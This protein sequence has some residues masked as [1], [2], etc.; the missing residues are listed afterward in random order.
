[1]IKN[2]N[3]IT[4]QGFMVNELG[5]KGNELLIYALIYGFSQDGVN[6][7]NGSLQYMADWCNIS[8]IAV[9]NGLKKLVEK[10][11]I[12]KEEKFI[13]NVKFCE[14]SVSIEGSKES[15][16]LVKNVN[17]GSKESLLG[18]SK[19][20]L[21]N[22]IDNKNIDI[23]INIYSQVISYLNEKT[24]KKYKITD[25]TKKMIRARQKEGYTLDDFKKV[26]DNKCND[27]LNTPYNIYLRPSTLFRPTKFE[28][29]L[30]EERPS[31]EIPDYSEAA[32]DISLSI[33]DDEYR[34]LIE[35][36]S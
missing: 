18:G 14:Y 19:E 10:G 3:F 29:Y 5:L 32:T 17:G 8:R 13:N 34:Q 28:G 21:P 7:F 16:P 1:M 9:I 33:S 31:K 27:W 22:N 12:T 6:K 24:G 26:I 35:R 30:N 20:S 23:N 11:L 36:K 25:S 4:I 2:E 15:L